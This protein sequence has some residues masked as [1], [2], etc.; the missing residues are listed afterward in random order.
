M[1]ASTGSSVVASSCT[2]ASPGVGHLDAVKG[3]PATGELSR[4]TCDTNHIDHSFACMQE[5]YLQGNSGINA[6]IVALCTSSFC[7]SILRLSMLKIMALSLMKIDDGDWD[8]I[9]AGSKMRRSR[10]GRERRKHNSCLSTWP[11]L[12]SQIEAV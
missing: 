12:S 5:S 9:T 3:C 10:T 1:A 6:K 2:N 8:V 11:P 4:M 7:M